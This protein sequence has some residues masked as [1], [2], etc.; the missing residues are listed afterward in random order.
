MTRKRIFRIL[1]VLVAL[2]LSIGL[3]ACGEKKTAKEVDT[4]A[5]AKID[6]Y[7][8]AEELE[9][10]ATVVLLAEKTEKE[11]NVVKDMGVPDTWNGYT[12]SMVRVKEI[13][14][15]TSG[16]EISIGEEIP[17]L[18]NQFTYTDDENTKVTCHINQYKMMEPGNDYFLY[19]YYSE[20][21]GWYV[22]LSGLFGKVPVSETEDVLFPT[23]EIT[24]FQ[25]QS[26]E[27]SMD[28]QSIL[29]IIREESLSRYE[30][31]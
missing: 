11:E 24:F 19:L 22:I 1:S 27:E 31:E 9:S 26:A 17:V 5:E 3:T 8:S 14:K 2:L 12:K 7:E 28:T 4:L 15:N 6:L 18:E 20:N 10:A 21:D 23:E 30:K 29:E 16:R 13:M 25:N